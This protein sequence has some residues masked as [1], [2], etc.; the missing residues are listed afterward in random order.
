MRLVIAHYATLYLQEPQFGATVAEIVNAGKVQ[1]S[2]TSKSVGGVSVSMDNSA[3]VSDLNGW[4]AWKLT[5]YGTQ[6]A[7][8]A[9]LVG[10]GGMYI[11]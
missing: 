5:T 10:K 7:Q 11:P 1:G 2:I 6:F 9:K 4:G 8:M 3:A